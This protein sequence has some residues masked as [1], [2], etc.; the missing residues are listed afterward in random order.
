MEQI[1]LEPDRL[2]MVNLSS[3]MGK[4]FADLMLETTQRIVELGPSPLRPNGA[5]PIR[6]HPSPSE[7]QD[8]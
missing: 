5:T 1:G 6:R 3:A 7:R 8:P 4:Q 2:R